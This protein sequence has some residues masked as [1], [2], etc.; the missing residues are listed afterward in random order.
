[1][2][3]MS[4]LEFE[5]LKSRLPDGVDENSIK[6]LKRGFMDELLD[7]IG[8]TNPYRTKYTAALKSIFD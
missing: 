3:R 7:E 1:M 5:A 8:S 6:I 2:V 4:V